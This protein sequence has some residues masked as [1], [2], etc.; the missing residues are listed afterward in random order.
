MTSVAAPLPDPPPVA[1]LREIGV[2]DDEIHRTAPADVWWRIHRTHGDFVLAWNEFRH[3][4]PLLRFDPHPEPTRLHTEYAVWYGASTPDAALAEAFQGRVIDRRRGLP[5]LTGLHFTRPLRLLDLATDSPGAWGTRAGGN[6]A[7]STAAHHITQRW[8]RA[9]IEAFPDID[10][11]R[12][13]SRFAGHPCVALFVSA[14]DAMPPEPV[15][16]YP[17][18]HPGLAARLAATAYRLGYDLV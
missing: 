5:Y 2:R 16:A 10:G 6:F 7:L 17:L 8:S 3:Y 9:I 14:A 12:Y 13:N 11:I 4:G 18:D 15:L 1:R